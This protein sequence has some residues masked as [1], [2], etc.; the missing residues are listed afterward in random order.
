[1]LVHTL[2]IHYHVLDLI[3]Q[4]IS[5]FQAVES[6]QLNTTNLFDQYH[7]VVESPVT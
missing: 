2:H 7:A 6:V 3:K 5:T 4:K 1:M